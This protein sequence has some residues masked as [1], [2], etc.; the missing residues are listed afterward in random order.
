MEKNS[1]WL[2]LNVRIIICKLQFSLIKL[3]NIQS[4]QVAD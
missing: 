3:I 4:A 1:K 2:Q